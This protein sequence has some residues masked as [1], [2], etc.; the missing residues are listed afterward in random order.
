MVRRL[1][2]SVRRALVIA[3]VIV[4]VGCVLASGLVLGLGFWSYALRGEVVR[5]VNLKVY[6][7]TTI[8]QVADSLHRLGAIENPEKM[9]KM[10][11]L[12]DLD[13]PRAGNY[14]FT[15]GETLRTLL[16]KINRAYQTPIRLTF[17]NFRTI[18]RLC[19]AIGR[20][21]MYDSLDFL[22]V[23]LSNSLLRGCGF[24][25]AT[26]LAMYLPNTYEVYW[27]VTPDQFAQMMYKE[28]QKFWTPR[29]LA[30]AQKL[31]LT[32][33]QVSTLA[34]IVI[35][36]TKAQSEMGDVAGV[37]LNRLKIGMP[38][39]ADPT[40]KFAVGDP[41]L[42]RIT[43]RHLKVQSPYNTYQ[44]RGLPPGLI[45]MP[46]IP[47]IDSVLSYNYGHKY[48]YFCAKADFSGRHAFAVTLGEHNRNAAAYAR[49]LNRRGIR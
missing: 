20:R 31:G 17:N 41:T 26:A 30:Q 40:V 10:A 37:Y 16:N 42:K 45:A 9:V 44:N 27:T 19:G 46:S 35:E 34:S 2:P 48:L 3:G 18:E 21:T 33:P 25:R 23:F 24:T 47:A 29:R 6:P 8:A 22:D 14:D 28:Y 7:G 13:N 11:K 32:P 36:E 43:N 4:G 5:P 39:Q 12:K 15:Q 49:E 1:K 38:L